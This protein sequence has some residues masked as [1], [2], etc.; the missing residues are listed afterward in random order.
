M[1]EPIEAN[2]TPDGDDWTITIK[3]RGKTLKATAPGIIAA[4]DRTDQLVEELAPDD[5][6]RTV[7]HLLNGD[8]VEFTTAYLTARMTTKSEPLPSAEA[9]Q[10]EPPEPAAEAAPEPKPA[11]KAPSPRPREP[12][13]A[14]AADEVASPS[15]S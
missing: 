14:S 3:G 11:K 6:Y 2:Y 12:E 7:V 13:E 1:A 4:R 5:E 8:A 10:A 15:A 9:E